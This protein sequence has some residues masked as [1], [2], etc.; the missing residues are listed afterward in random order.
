M[1]IFNGLQQSVHRPGST[2]ALC[3]DHRADPTLLQSHS[4]C[5]CEV[6]RLAVCFP[7]LSF[8]TAVPIGWAFCTIEFHRFL[9][10]QGSQDAYGACEK[11][12]NYLGS[13]AF[14]KYCFIFTIL[15]TK[16]FT[17]GAFHVCSET[18]WWMFLFKILWGKKNV[19]KCVLLHLAILHNREWIESY[20]DPSLRNPLNYL[21]LF[22]TI[23]HSHLLISIDP[24]LEQSRET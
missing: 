3:M 24:C 13:Q 16:Y 17:H 1:H 4:F 21:F 15:I 19:W 5:G 10:S 14:S 11:Q 8:S 12:H 23:N 9:E 20:C 18:L 22:F 2:G 7:S 6:N